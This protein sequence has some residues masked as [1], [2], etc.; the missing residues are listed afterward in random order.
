MISSNVG[1]TTCGRNTALFKSLGSMHSRTDP[2]FFMTHTKE[3]T[4]GVGF[5]TG[6]IMSSNIEHEMLAVVSGFKK[7]HHYIWGQAVTIQT[8]HKPLESIAIKNLANAPPR[9][10]RMLLKIQGYDFTV[11]YNPGKSIPIADSMSRVSPSPEEPMSDV[12]IHIHLLN[13]H[14]NASPTCLIDIKVETFKDSVL[15]ELTN[16]IMSGWPPS[17]TSFLEL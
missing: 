1:V 2:L 9:L 6:V 3:L 11:K 16:T 7:F 15:K 8:D 12:D 10:A 14:L 4:Q 17:Y 13:A 5:V